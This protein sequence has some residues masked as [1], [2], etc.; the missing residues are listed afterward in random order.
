MKYLCLAYEE[1]TKLNALSRSEW[2]SLRGETLAH[3]ESL[4]ES[5]QLIATNC[6]S[7]CLAGRAR[8]P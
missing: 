8:H 4:R 2:D 5:G 3:V 7:R 6:R 1:E